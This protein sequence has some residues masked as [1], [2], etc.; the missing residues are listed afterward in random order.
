MLDVEY[1][2]AEIYLARIEIHPD[3]QGGSIGTRLISAFIDEAGRKAKI[4]R[5]PSWRGL[6]PDKNPGD[7]YRDSRAPP[8]R[9]PSR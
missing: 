7:L 2:P 9:Q 4:L 1:R 8:H 3:H 6:R 5:H